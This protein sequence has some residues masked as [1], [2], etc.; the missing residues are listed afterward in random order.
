MVMSFHDPVYIA[1]QSL[2]ELKGS[3]SYNEI[4]S[5]A[6]LKRQKAIDIIL[7]NKHLLK[8]DKKGKV[9]GFISH[10]SNV[11]RNVEAMFTQGLVYKTEEINYGADKVIIVHELY[12]EKIKHLIKPYWVGGLGDNYKTECVIL[13]PD[14]KKALNDLGFQDFNEIVDKKLANNECKVWSDWMIP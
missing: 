5:V 7:R 2:T 8:I 14:N 10:K 3:A 13:N 1:I 12:K 11:I 4:A 6:G 9:I